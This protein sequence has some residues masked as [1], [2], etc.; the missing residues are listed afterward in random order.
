MDATIMDT[1]LSLGYLL[2]RAARLFPK[3][4]IVSH[5]PD[6]STHRY[7]YS[8][9]R[10]RARALAQGLIQH[11]LQPGDRV[12]T[13][14]WN[15]YAHV[16]A[17]FGVPMAG[18][19][20]HTLNLRL[21]PAE[22]ARIANHAGDRFLIV[23]DV[24]LPL[25]EQFVGD[26]PFEK[27]F[28]VPLSESATPPD[29]RNYEELLAVDDEKWVPAEVD[30]NQTVGLCYTSGTTGQP[31]GVAYSHRA[32][33]LHSFALAMPDSLCIRQADVVMP[34]VPMF[35]VNAWGL[36]F[37]STMTGS[38]QVLPGPLMDPESLLDLMDS[39]QVTVAGGVPTIAMGLL[40]SIESEP[41]RWTLTEGLRMVIGGSAVPESLMRNMDTRGIRIIHAWGMTE[42]SPLGTLSFLKSDLESLD[43]ERQ[44]GYR[45][46]Q[47]IPLPYVQIRAVHEGDEVAWDGATQG[48]LQVRGPWVA[49]AY[50]NE[51]GITENWTDDGWFRTGDVV[52][53]D[54]EGYME[55]TD[56]TKDLIKS[57]GEWISSIA[58]ENA[59]MGH[60]DVDEAAVIAVPH[61]KWIERP[62]AIVVIK[63]GQSCSPDTLRDFLAGMFPK[64]WLPEDF[65]T[66]VSI[67]RTS[68]GKFLKTQLRDEY[69]SWP[70]IT[71]SPS[72]S[73][74]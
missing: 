6:R 60:P 47:G 74:H 35:H 31:K 49:S 1:Q 34:I 30:E 51:P 61:P 45:L 39:E 43:A 69:K 8:D 25:L 36:P 3:V 21:P 42:T 63:T 38:K 66:R 32:L 9:L 62:L 22:I 50:F 41:G 57:G 14:M 10:Q 64:W 33:A 17:Y 29:Y 28:V 70:S 7:G 40:S 65:V 72:Q 11:G 12:A 54:T 55:I 16:E 24:L 48:E 37:A 56:R 4:E 18:G 23:D 52:T 5:L 2:E 73:T 27:I 20:Y 58:L 71:S 67:P 44:L 19:I 46:K 15:H 26:A 68:T 53:I 59:L 13:L